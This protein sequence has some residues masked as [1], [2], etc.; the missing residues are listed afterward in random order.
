M[1]TGKAMEQ[2]EKTRRLLDAGI[3]EELSSWQ[4][5]ISILSWQG[6]K[7]KA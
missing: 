1:Q 7:E 3:D 6:G 5:V 4:I 2:I